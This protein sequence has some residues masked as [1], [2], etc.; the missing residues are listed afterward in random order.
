MRETP[1]PNRRLDLDAAYLAAEQVLA[2]D[3]AAQRRRAAVLAAVQAATPS[4]VQELTNH[5]T[6]KK[7]AANEPQWWRGGLAWRG[8][9]AASVMLC[10]SLLVWR[11]GEEPGAVLGDNK[12]AVGCGPQASTNINTDTR[13]QT[14]TH[15]SSSTSTDAQSKALSRTHNDGKKRD[16]AG[17]C[18]R[19]ALACACADACRGRNAQR[20]VRC[21]AHCSA[22]CSADCSAC[23]SANGSANGSATR[24]GARVHQ[25][26]ATCI[27][28]PQRGACARRPATSACG[29]G[30]ASPGSIVWRIG[31]WRRSPAGCARCGHHRQALGA[32]QGSGR[33]RPRQR[34]PHRLGPGS[35]AR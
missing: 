21:S 8:A 28:A 24:C 35:A 27:A 11:V 12:V 29:A 34:R 26:P 22:D 1:D 13:T 9:V 14:S 3:T 2:D 20:G 7:Q 18:C 15:I 4:P 23:C 25:H 30:R 19:C 16:D 17:R 31:G 6:D 32:A 33:P 10:S 5:I